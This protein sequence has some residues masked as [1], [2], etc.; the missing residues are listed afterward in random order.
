MQVRAGRPS[1]RAYSAEKLPFADNIALAALDLMHVAKIQ[2]FAGPGSYFYGAA[3]KTCPAGAYNYA[4]GG[5]QYA[6]ALS[7]LYV[8]AVMK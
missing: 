6:G 4:V 1:G 5:T 8:Y 3:H 2:S 7:G